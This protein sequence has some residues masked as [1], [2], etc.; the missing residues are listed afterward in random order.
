MSKEL[1]GIAKAWEAK[2]RKSVCSV[3]KRGKSVITPMPLESDEEEHEPG[4]IYLVEKIFPNGDFYTGQWCDYV[5]QGQGKYLWTDGCMY[6]G[7][8]EKGK[9]NGKGMFSWPS[10]ATYEGEFKTGFMD[11]TGTYTGSSGDTYK[12]SWVM[13]MKHG[14]GTK[15]HPNGDFYDG[16]WKKEVQ[17]GHGRYQWRKGNYYIG[18]WKNGKFHGNGTLMWT[19]GNRYDGSWEEGFPK[20]N[21]TFKWADGSFYAGV[22]SND[23]KEQSGT[24]YPPGSTTSGHLDWDPQEVFSM[25]LNDCQVCPCENVPIYPSGKRL[26]LFEGDLM[27]SLSRKVSDAARRTRWV[28]VDR[29][30]SSS[31]SQDLPRSSDVDGRLRDGFESMGD[32]Q[33]DDSAPRASFS[34]KPPHLILKPVK[35]QGETI[36]KGHKNYD[37]MINLQLGIRY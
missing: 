28:S 3:K 34:S 16:E 1:K 27:Q 9:T 37:L 29:R 35:R 33:F 20:G 8:W 12:G 32:L 10:G 30:L 6:V 31:S 25:V 5:P 14:K 36:S 4:E 18:Q 2:V 26:S 15:S 19:D 23:P 7:E 22:W 11:G 17:E 13:N 24:Y 21:G